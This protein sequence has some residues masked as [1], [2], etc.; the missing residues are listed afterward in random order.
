MCQKYVKLSEIRV[1]VKQTSNLLEMRQD[2]LK[3]NEKLSKNQK[4]IKTVK[5]YKTNCQT[6]RNLYGCQKDVKSVKKRVKL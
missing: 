4:Y 6:V 2:K 5:K 3:N 1:N